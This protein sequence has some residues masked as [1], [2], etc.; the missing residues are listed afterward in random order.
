MSYQ[1][2]DVNGYVGDIAT[3]KGMQDFEEWA[4]TLKNKDAVNSFLK[5]GMHIDPISLAEAL[6]EVDPDDETVATTHENLMFLLKK[7]KEITIIN[8]GLNDDL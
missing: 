4:G 1:L 7:C 3:N 2:Y 5:K 6:D 8:D